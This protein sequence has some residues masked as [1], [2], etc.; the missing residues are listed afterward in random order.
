M[1][2]IQENRLFQEEDALSMEWNFIAE[3]NKEEMIQEEEKYAKIFVTLN[4]ET[5]I[6]NLPKST[7][8]LEYSMFDLKGIIKREFKLTNDKTLKIFFNNKS[9]LVS[10]DL[11]LKQLLDLKLQIPLE[12]EVFLTENKHCILCMKSNCYH[13][14]NVQQVDKKRKK[15]ENRLEINILEPELSYIQQPTEK[16]SSTISCTKKRR[17]VSCTKNLGSSQNLLIPQSG[18]FIL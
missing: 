4:N 18:S 15:L 9:I 11:V 17:V 12:I 6:I 8:T 7:L 2:K 10:N 3:D 5:K 1:F 13:N 16:C 14:S